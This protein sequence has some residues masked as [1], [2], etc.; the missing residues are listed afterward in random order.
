MSYIPRSDR[1]TIA[2]PDGTQV[3]FTY[4][5]GQNPKSADTRS[6]VTAALGLGA[7]MRQTGQAGC[8]L[9]NPGSIVQCL[10]APLGRSIDRASITCLLT[11]P[12]S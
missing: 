1:V 3:G 8:L 6:P 7:G 5:A 10:T 12:T 4:D 2:Y 9:G 11:L